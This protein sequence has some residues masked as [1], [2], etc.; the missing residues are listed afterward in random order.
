MR[1]QHCHLCNHVA[2]V[3]IYKEKQNTEL[4]AVMEENEEE[5]EDRGS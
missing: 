2:S 4:D 5:E 3:S 1:E